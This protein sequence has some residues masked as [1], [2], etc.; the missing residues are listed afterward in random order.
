MRK[1]KSFFINFR[2]WFLESSLRIKVLVIALVLTIGW[3]GTTQVLGLSKKQPQYQTAKVQKGSIISTVNES[4]NVASSSQASVMSPTTGVIEQIYVNNGDEVVEGQNLFLVKST[5]SAQEAASAWAAYQNTIVSANSASDNKIVNQATLEKD[6]QAVISASTAV[7]NMQNAGGTNG[8]NPSTKQN[9]TQNDI[10]V[11]NSSLVSARETFSADEQK[12]NHSG[13]N[14]G[15]AGASENSAWLAYQAT[16]DSVVTAPIGGTVA[17]IS[18]K[19]GDQVAA[20]GGSLGVGSSGGGTG[21]NS[22]TSSNSVSGSSSSTSSNAVLYIG[23]F[24]SLYVKV[25]ASEVDIT[26]IKPGQKA[27]IT[28]S[29]FPNKTF[30]GTVDQ[31][32]ST[33]TVSSGVVTY[34]VYVAITAPPPDIK[35]GM[36]ASVTIQ[37]EIRDNALYV[38][39]AA[40]QSSGGVSSVRVLKNGQI[41]NVD[42]ETGI[43]S[44]TDT[45]ITSGLTEGET[46]VTGVTTQTSTSGQAASP[47]SSLGGGRGGFGG[48]FGGGGGRTGGA[49]AGR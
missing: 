34:N 40:I 23:D 27:T 5:A 19:P 15:A 3:F 42:V 45:E 18:V 7:T 41:S 11:L 20:S 47:F 30:V 38:P 39:T 25:Q 28:L 37:T 14:I 6:R 17:N 43:S 4:G 44:D 33:G 31:L 10:D 1:L 48:G 26:N 22:S 49:G 16:Q 9:Y 46:V 32:D 24:S 2:V 35:P 36:S 29:A 13:Q 12:Y 21:N 8:T